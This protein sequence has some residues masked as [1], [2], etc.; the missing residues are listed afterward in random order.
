[1]KRPSTLKTYQFSGESKG[2]PK[3]DW[4]HIKMRGIHDTLR[5]FIAQNFHD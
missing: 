3:K 2:V 1:M 4:I 5:R